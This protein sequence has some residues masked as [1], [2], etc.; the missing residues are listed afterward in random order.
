ATQYMPAEKIPEGLIGWYTSFW[1]AAWKAAKETVAPPQIQS[2]QIAGLP[3]IQILEIKAILYPEKLAEISK[4]IRILDAFEK[5][6]KQ[7]KDALAG[8]QPNEIQYLK[9][10][11]GGNST[12]EITDQFDSLK[13]IHDQT[14]QFQ[15]L[16][17]DGESSLEPLKRR[18]REKLIDPLS[19][20]VEELENQLKSINNQWENPD[21]LISV[22]D[23]DGMQSNSKSLSQQL[24]VL[25]QKLAK[26]RDLEF[27]LNRILE[28]EKYSRDPIAFLTYLD[29]LHNTLTY[30]KG[31]EQYGF[32]NLDDRE[33]SA[34]ISKK[35]DEISTVILSI[36]NV[37]PNL[38]MWLNAKQSLEIQ[39][40]ELFDFFTSD[41]FTSEDF[42]K[43]KEKLPNL[44]A[45]QGWRDSVVSWFGKVFVQLNDYIYGFFG[46]DAGVS[47][48]KALEKFFEGGGEISLSRT[49]PEVG[50]PLEK[51]YAKIA[52]TK[53]FENLPQSG[54]FNAAMPA[55]MVLF[56]HSQGFLHLFSPTRDA[57]SFFGRLTD[58]DE[59]SYGEES[60]AGKVGIVQ[61][62]WERLKYYFLSSLALA[63]NTVSPKMPMSSQL[64]YLMIYSPSGSQYLSRKMEEAQS[65]G[66]DLS[67]V[68]SKV[69]QRD[70][71]DFIKYLKERVI[72]D[73]QR[74]PRL[75]RQVSYLID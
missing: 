74:N 52:L 70:L 51:T 29:D 57:A 42:K 17:K 49:I 22:N 5:A 35:V 20:K 14:D 4:T 2:F 45:D 38:L 21:S 16:V 55:L 53:V 75:L 41:R 64:H 34:A 72:P 12:V 48:L 54:K 31:N 65:Q 13:H 60:M 8:L 28:F 1:K 58:W 39:K 15:K 23:S 46:K 66:G 68:L 32:F 30:L 47:P 44:L 62:P 71:D 63:S 73:I 56:G 19:Q 9:E 69:S 40:Q 10:L 6:K 59:T 26:L 37:R 11:L 7:G 33:L 36:R 3:P 67:S 18:L 50:E 27:Q 43:L 24:G 61:E 25:Q